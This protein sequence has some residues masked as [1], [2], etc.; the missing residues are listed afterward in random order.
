MK[1]I[2]GFYEGLTNIPICYVVNRFTVTRDVRKAFEYD[3]S[4]K[5]IK[6]S[7][8]ILKGIYNGSDSGNMTEHEYY[9]IREDYFKGIKMVDVKPLI[10]TKDQE[11]V[12]LRLLKLNKIYDKSG[13]RGNTEQVQGR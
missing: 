7:R 5:L 10:V 2:L 8:E 13:I 1:Y 12:H 4:T 3:E 9:H 11:I 6:F